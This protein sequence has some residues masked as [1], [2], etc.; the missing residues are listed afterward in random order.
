MV[1]RWCLK[2][3]AA[4]L[5]KWSYLLYDAVGHHH[6]TIFYGWLG[7]GRNHPGPV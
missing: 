4:E 3:F 1:L 6:R 5:L 2:P 7:Y